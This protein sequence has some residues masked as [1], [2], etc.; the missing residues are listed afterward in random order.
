M[1]AK[2]VLLIAIIAAL[3]ATGCTKHTIVADRTLKVGNI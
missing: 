2:K 1:N 3:L